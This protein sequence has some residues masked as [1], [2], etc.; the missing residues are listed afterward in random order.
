[1]YHVPASTGLLVQPSQIMLTHSRSNRRVRS[2]SRSWPLRQV[3]M[4]LKAFFLSFFSADG[5]PTQVICVMMMISGW[6]WRAWGRDGEKQSAARVYQSACCTS[7]SRPGIRGRACTRPRRVVRAR[8]PGRGEPPATAW[9][10]RRGGSR[11]G[12]LHRAGR[13]H[14]RRKTRLANKPTGLFELEKV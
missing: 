7:A 10:R 14:A 11:A 5:Y 1:M 8:G 2:C 3:P 6:Q 13:S 4:W 9:P 12:D